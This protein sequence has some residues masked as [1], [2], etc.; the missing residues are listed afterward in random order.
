MPS[1]FPG[2][3]PYLENPVHWSDFHH[4]FISALRRSIAQ[5]LPEPYYAKIDEHVTIVDPE[6]T[7]DPRLVKPDVTVGRAPSPANTGS[8]VAE[9]DAE[10]E[11]LAN[12]VYLDPITQGFIE[13]KR[14]P[15][16]EL[17]TVVEVLSPA[18]KN[19]GRGQYLEKRELLLRK[20]VSIVELDLLR[21]GRRLQLSK[22]PI[23]ADY[24][25]FI[26]RADRRP[27]CAA[28]RWNVRRR[29]P[30]VPIPL[31]PG[32]P[33]IRVDIQEAFMEAFARGDYD[34]FIDYGEPPP[35]PPFGEE[36]EQWVTQ[37]ARTGL[38]EH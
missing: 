22:P 29:L 18:N 5:R 25:A 12:I 33:D 32:D 31:R 35:P 11:V 1:P 4:E 28:Y 9:A 34:R 8:A 6:L 17:V 16:H 21:G 14:R 36:D 26:S 38:K 13:I 24:Y 3:D 20:P 19:G 10:A 27:S 2:M 23:K 7:T 15:D 30:A 37:T